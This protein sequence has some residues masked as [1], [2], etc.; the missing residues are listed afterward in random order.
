MIEEFAESPGSDLLVTAPT[1][2][3][4]TE[5]VFL[6]LL[7]ELMGESLPYGF[8]LLYICPLK[9]LVDCKTATLTRI[10]A[11]QALS[12]RLEPKANV[13]RYDTLRRK[14]AGRAS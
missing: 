7:S 5:V 13:A 2:T 4:K 14:E 1:A 10:D 6:P 11:P 9:K 12:L 3:G 8:E